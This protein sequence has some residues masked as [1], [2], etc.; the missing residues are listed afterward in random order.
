MEALLPRVP[1]AAKR[2][3]RFA[4]LLLAIVLFTLVV[5][6]L[7]AVFTPLAVAAAIAY[8]LNPAV[9]WIERRGR[10]P[11]LAVVSV[12]FVLLLVVVASGGLFVGGKVIAQ[13][14]VLQRQIPRYVQL[15]QQWLP[16]E[17][18]ATSA[19]A[20]PDDDP[21]D[22]PASVPSTGE[23]W[24][25]WLLPLVEQ[26]GATVARSTVG[27][28]GQAFAGLGNILVRFVLVAVFTFYFLWR[29][30]AFVRRIDGNLPRRHRE[31]IVH[32]VTVIDRAISEFFRGRVIV[33]LV[34]GLLSGIGW[35][36]VGVPYNWALGLLVALLNLVPFLSTLALIPA[37]LCAY[38]GAAEVG[39]PWLWP[40]MLTMG[41]FMLVQALESFL[42]APLVYG[43]TSGLHPLAIVVALLIGAELAGLLGLLLAIPIASTLKTLTVELVGPPLTRWLADEGEVTAENE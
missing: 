31:R 2:W 27:Y 15:A 16:G 42:L 8:I 12:T 23:L 30:D 17:T 1:E 39:A 43:S 41:V 7:R 33:C 34:V 35:A 25:S 20:T 40:I 32:I 14:H 11:R 5:H 10:L 6:R 13:A 19:P 26:H 18:P 9:T 38:F 29:F 36:I 22:A 37:L 3:I 4:I 28:A 21:Q 24:W